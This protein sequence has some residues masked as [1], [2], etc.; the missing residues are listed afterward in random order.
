MAGQL[1]HGSHY[2]RVGGSQGIGD[3]R[4]EQ[5]RRGGERAKYERR[6]P[7]VSTIHSSWVEFGCR[8]LPDSFGRA[9][10]I[11]ATSATT[12]TTHDDISAGIAHDGAEPTAPGLWTKPGLWTDMTRTPWPG[13][14]TR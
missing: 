11:A 4:G 2:G 9:R 1:I 10:L 14:A 8:P 6:V 13:T 12:T 3:E 5:Q 7:A